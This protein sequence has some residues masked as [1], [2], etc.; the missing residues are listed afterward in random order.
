MLTVAPDRAPP[1]TVRLNVLVAVPPLVEV[2]VRVI[3]KV[4]VW[5]EA[6]A[7]KVTDAVQ[8]GEGVQVGGDGVKF[9]VTPV[10]RVERLKVTGWAVPLVK[11]AVSVTEPLVAP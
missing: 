8:L 7:V 2:P 1:L 9:G 5:A 3:V 6:V 11:V 4:P 10:G